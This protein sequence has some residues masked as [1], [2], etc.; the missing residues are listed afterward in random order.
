M[1]RLAR[2]IIDLFIDR[3]D[4][5]FLLLCGDKILWYINVYI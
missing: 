3:V 5:F 4:L 1:V 2:I